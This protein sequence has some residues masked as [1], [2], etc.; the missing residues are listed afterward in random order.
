MPEVILNE[1]G[2]DLA[3]R[4]IGTLIVFHRTDESGLPW[5]VAKVIAK[6]T[7]CT[8]AAFWMKQDA[9]GWAKRETEKQV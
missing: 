7:T 3:E 2:S 1:E 6:R 5:K 4:P 9:L 8:I